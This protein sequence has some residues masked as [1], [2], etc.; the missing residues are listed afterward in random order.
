MSLIEELKCKTLLKL[1]LIQGYT[2]DELCTMD[3]LY[4]NKLYNYD[5]KNFKYLPSNINIRISFKNKNFFKVLDKINKLGLQNKIIIAYKINDQEKLNEFLINSNIIGQKIYIGTLFEDRNI[6]EYLQ[7]EKRLYE[8]VKPTENLSPFEKYIYIYNL[9][10]NYK[11]YNE[12]PK[13]LLDSRDIYRVLDNEYMTCTGYSLLFNNLLN[14]VGINNMVYKKEVI[15]IGDDHLRSYVHIKDKKYGIDGFYCADTTY[16]NNL[17]IDRYD[18]LAL[19]NIDEVDKSLEFVVNDEEYL[20]T[21]LNQQ[22]FIDK[23][24][25]IRIYSDKIMKSIINIMKNLDPNT[26]KLFKRKY[27]ETNN[28]E[29]LFDISNYYVKHINKTI[30]NHTIEFALREVLE[31]TTNLSRDEI[32]RKI[33]E[34]NL[35]HMIKEKTR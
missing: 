12:N 8:M 22:E 9:V 25:Q 20:F 3:T 29:F 13:D 4:I 10:K 32:N 2:Y 21:S 33:N 7:Y 18:F 28:N 6:F 15:D 19:T 23:I 34:I 27:K 16:D 31:K 24:N 11:Q 14:K 35:M 1:P 17:N 5:L 26:Y 30:P